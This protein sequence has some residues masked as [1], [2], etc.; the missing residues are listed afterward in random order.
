MKARETNQPLC[1]LIAALGGQ[2]GGVLMNWIVSAA[3]AAGHEVQAT[4]VPGVAQRTVDR[5][6]AVLEAQDI[7]RGELAAA[8][9]LDHL[10]GAARAKALLEVAPEP[11]HELLLDKARAGEAAQPQPVGHRLLALRPGALGRRQRG[12]EENQRLAHVESLLR[13]SRLGFP[14]KTPQVPSADARSSEKA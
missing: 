9:P 13:L 3:R 6:L 7:A 8:E 2:G 11:P 10:F 14:Q 5:R 12:Q 1:I 4:S